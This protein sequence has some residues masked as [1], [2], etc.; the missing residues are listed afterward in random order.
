MKCNKMIAFF[1]YDVSTVETF[2]HPWS[3]ACLWSLY[4]QNGAQVSSASP[5]GKIE[6]NQH[7]PL[8]QVWVPHQWAVETLMPKGKR[9]RQ[10]IWRALKKFRVIIK[11]AR[12]QHTRFGNTSGKSL[13][14]QR[15]RF[16]ASNRIFSSSAAALTFKIESAVDQQPTRPTLWFDQ[17]ATTNGQ[18]QLSS[19]LSAP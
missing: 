15:N 12:L 17:T 19:K 13:E 9:L 11:I 16:K 3:C 6:K 18:V 14:R 7:L 2:L 10:L 1:H 4:C 8:T 5:R